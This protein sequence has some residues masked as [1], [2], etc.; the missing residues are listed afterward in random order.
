MLVTSPRPRGTNDITKLSILNK[1]YFKQRGMYF[2]G[3]QSR[4][5]TRT[6]RKEGR[7][8]LSLDFTPIGWSKSLTPIF[9]VMTNSGVSQNMARCPTMAERYNTSLFEIECTLSSEY[10]CRLGLLISHECHK[11]WL[12]YFILCV[13]V[14][15]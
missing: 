6:D 15:N 11:F 10:N 5:Y 9:F 8:T 3:S 1:S 7:Q 2:C 13:P 12:F 4:T 14:N